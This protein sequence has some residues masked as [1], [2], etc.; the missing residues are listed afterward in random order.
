[1]EEA[2]AEV[3][4]SPEARDLI[5]KLLCDSE[6]RLGRIDSEEIKA[7]PFFAKINWVNLR[8]VFSSFFSL[9]PLVYTTN[10][11]CPF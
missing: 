11:F 1:M 4:L 3:D 10:I 5:G 8:S 7:H 6:Y 9:H 2:A